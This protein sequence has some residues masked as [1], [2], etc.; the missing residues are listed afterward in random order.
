MGTTVSHN[1]LISRLSVRV[2][3]SIE[4]TGALAADVL[5]S[6]AVRV[7]MAK[8]AHFRSELDDAEDT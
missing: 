4:S 6:E 2:A 3:V 5:F 7:L 8:C 1:A